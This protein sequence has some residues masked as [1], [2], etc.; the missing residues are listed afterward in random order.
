MEPPAVHFY[1][2]RGRHAPD[3]S[4]YAPGPKPPPPGT[5][6]RI[7]TG[8]G[9]IL[10]DDATYGVKPLPSIPQRRDV[11]AWGSDITCPACLERS[12]RP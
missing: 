6:H 1:V 2:S 12:P 8:C 4:W 5:R 3:G 11:T 9:L 10:D 7:I